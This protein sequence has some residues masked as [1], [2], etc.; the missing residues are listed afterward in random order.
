MVRQISLLKEISPLT[1]ILVIGVTDMAANEGD[2]IISYKNIPA[3]IDA[4]KR[5]TLK[6]DVAFWDSYRAM[7]GKSSIIKWAEKKPPCSQSLRF[8]DQKT[9]GIINYCYKNQNK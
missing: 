6:A 7:G 1:H 8:I 2:S 5:A 9:A 4:Q 3:I